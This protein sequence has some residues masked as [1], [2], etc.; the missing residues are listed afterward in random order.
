MQ[1]PV[2]TRS[3]YRGDGRPKVVYTS[4]DDAM[5]AVAENLYGERVH[6]YRCTECLQWHT[7]RN[8]PA[9]GFTERPPG[10]H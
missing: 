1:V 8:R 4:F 6:A 5:Q 10:I 7:G 2:P 9:R 3:C